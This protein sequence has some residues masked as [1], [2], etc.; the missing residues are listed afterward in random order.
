[1][2]VTCF[3]Y[4]FQA[5]AKSEQN[6]IN[7]FYPYCQHNV[8]NGGDR[9]MMYTNPDVIVESI[10]KAIKHWKNKNSNTKDS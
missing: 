5:W 10:R 7:S 3:W 6:L 8:V 4:I 2:L 9:H 1:M